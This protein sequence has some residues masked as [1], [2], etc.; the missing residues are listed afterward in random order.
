MI[1]VLFKDACLVKHVLFLTQALVSELATIRDRSEYLNVIGA[2]REPFA[3]EYVL[4][5]EKAVNARLKH[6]R[7][8][9][10]NGEK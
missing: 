4:V 5:A 6:L 8:Q 1:A 7:K 9:H 10:M 2:I 3:R